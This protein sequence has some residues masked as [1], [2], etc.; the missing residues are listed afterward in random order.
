MIAESFERIHRS[1]LIGMGILPLQLAEG[2]D[3]AALKLTGDECISIAGLAKLTP[4]SGVTV[5]VQPERG[6]PWVLKT[7]CRIDTQDEL[8]FFRHGG[9]LQCR[10]RELIAPSIAEPMIDA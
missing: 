4:G 9:I 8:R 10:L 5:Q 1:N 2:T 7:R 6:A 3:F